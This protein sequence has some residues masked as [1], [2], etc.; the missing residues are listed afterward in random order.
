MTLKIPET[1]LPK[2]LETERL[3]LRPLTTDDAERIVTLA[4]NPNISYLL[5]SMPHPY[6]MD[7][8][9]AFLARAQKEN[10]HVFGI[11]LKSNK[12]L[13]IGTV[14]VGPRWSKEEP[15]VGFWLGQDYWEHQYTAEA[16]RAILTY[17]FE[18]LNYEKVYC[19]CRIDNEKP[20]NV[21]SFCNFVYLGR[22]ERHFHDPHE[23]HALDKYFLTRQMWKEVNHTALKAAQ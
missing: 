18:F 11:C 14:G 7:H 21:I 6:T 3:H 1:S 4:N 10:L 22:T 12:N 13:L 2:T 9:K 15:E 17:A 5:G 20:R 16:V 19:S 23:T 8:A